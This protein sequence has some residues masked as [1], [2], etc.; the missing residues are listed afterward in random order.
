MTYRIDISSVAK[1]EIDAAFY[2]GLMML[3]FMYRGRS[4]PFR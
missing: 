3:A 2:R 1:V 4:H